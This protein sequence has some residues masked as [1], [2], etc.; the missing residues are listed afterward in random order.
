MI[1]F[2]VD[3]IIQTSCFSFLEKVAE[4]DFYEQSSR[5]VSLAVS[6]SWNSWCILHSTYLSNAQIRIALSKARV[7]YDMSNFSLE[8]HLC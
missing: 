8:A 2:F 3:N 1:Y 6:A 7:L 5:H 4:A